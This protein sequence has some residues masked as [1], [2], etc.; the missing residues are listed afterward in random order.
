[1]N[2]FILYGY[3]QS[4]TSF[5][6]LCKSLPTFSVTIPNEQGL[7]NA[8]AHQPLK[9]CV[10][11]LRT[12]AEIL[13]NHPKFKNL[14]LKG[15]IMTVGGTPFEIYNEHPAVDYTFA[16]PETC[17]IYDKSQP[18]TKRFDP[19]KNPHGFKTQIKSISITV[20]N[21][22][23]VLTSN[24]PIFNFGGK[25]YVWYN[26][27]YCENGKDPYMKLIMNE[28]YEPALPFNITT[29]SN[30]FADAKFLREQYNRLVTE[31]CS[32]KELDMIV[33]VLI[34]EKDGYATAKPI[35]SE[36]HLAIIE[37]QKQPEKVLNN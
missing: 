19:E 11:F 20:K 33:P 12:N 6:E 21:D 36:K 23:K 3:P 13:K 18:F 14:N 30:N 28:C 5:F 4:A 8:R 24:A 34:S 31:G 9:T 15:K 2:E 35:F 10:N 7:K 25:E 29:C 17:I 22:R 1:M 16:R 37:S 27:Q 26:K 32:P